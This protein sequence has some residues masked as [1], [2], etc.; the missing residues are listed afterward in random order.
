VDRMGDTIAVDG[1][2]LDNYRKNPV[3]LFAHDSNQL[4]VGKSL[5]EWTD[6]GALRSQ[7][8]FTPR[9]MN[10][11][12]ASVGAL[13]RGGFLRATS[14]GFAPD[15]WKVNEE[16]SGH[17]WGPAIDY[18]KQ[19]LLEFSW[20][21]IPA[22]PDA[23][24]GAKAAGIDLAPIVEWAERTLDRVSGDGLWVPRGLVEA[25]WGKIADRKTYSF[26]APAQTKGMDEAMEAMVARCEAACDKSA[27]AC[28][29]TTAACEAMLAEMGDDKSTST[30]LTADQIAA[31]VKT[32][33]SEAAKPRQ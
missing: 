19:E 15:E 28:D 17:G 9:E 1:W 4:P 11:M 14:V 33:M 6:G 18:L 25:T 23:L 22:N 20:V 30:S 31:A 21:P 13:V 26:P 24:V 2:R 8:E 12:G 10:P 3:V 27:A 16:R 5:R 7:M 32:G 29:K